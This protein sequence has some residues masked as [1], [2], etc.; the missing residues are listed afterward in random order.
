DLPWRLPHPSLQAAPTQIRRV[1]ELALRIKYGH[2]VIRLSVVLRLKSVQGGGE[3]SRAIRSGNA[4]DR[5]AAVWRG[6]HP[7]AHALIVAPQV[8]A[9][10][11]LAGRVVLRHERRHR[12]AWRRG[13][14]AGVQYGKVRDL[15]GA[16]HVNIPQNVASGV[17]AESKRIG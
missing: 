4:D 1:L 9:P 7:N 5:H 13:R 15:G 11:Q 17:L 3:R 14:L 2:K 8:G 12:A 6:S 16:G 10:K